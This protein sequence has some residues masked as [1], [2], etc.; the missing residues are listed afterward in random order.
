MNRSSSARF[1]SASISF[2]C[3]N[4]AV[5][6][7]AQQP[8]PVRVPDAPSCSICTITMK[9][10]VVL[11]DTTGP[12]KLTDPPN[13]FY[14]DAHGDYWVLGQGSPL[15]FDS[16]GGFRLR[17]S[18]PGSGRILGVF[19]VVRVGDDSVAILDPPSRR[20][21][22]AGPDHRIS[23]EISTPEFR[24]DAAAVL[25]WPTSVV[26]S[27][28]IKSSEAIG[29]PLHQASFAGASAVVSSSFSPGDGSALLGEDLRQRL[30]ATSPQVF[31]SLDR[32]QYRLV[33]WRLGAGAQH[34]L[35]RSPSWF[36]KR[37]G[38]SLGGPAR[39]PDS[40]TTAFYADDLGLIW[41]FSRVAAD[42]WRSAWPA[43]IPQTGVA[44]IPIRSIR[45]DRLFNTMV[46]VIDPRTSRVV[47]RSLIEGWVV[48]A[49]PGR[50]A[51]WS[52]SNS[53]SGHLKIIATA[54]SGWR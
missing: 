27:A 45:V 42:S 33:E 6:A 40:Q 16:T 17:V 47:T 29:L 31:W 41:V 19:G 50:V 35:E 11:G 10:L 36:S 3:I 28:D 21:L 34:V 23:R 4:V 2:L 38:S 12:A 49:S 9:D 43:D 14:V 46:E 32:E 8:A 26:I 7:Q 5:G 22:I 44:E 52:M 51:V 54:L 30:F 39:A 24:V 13:G 48:G 37:S 20:V 25:S 53:G 15:V 1:L 18:D